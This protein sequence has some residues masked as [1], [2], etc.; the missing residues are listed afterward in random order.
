MEIIKK[1]ATFHEKVD[2]GKTQPIYD[3]KKIEKEVFTYNGRMFNTLEEAEHYKIK[4]DFISNLE[5]E[6]LNNT[7]AGYVENVYLFELTDYIKF[8]LNDSKL[9]DITTIKNFKGYLNRD[10]RISDME[11]GKYLF[12]DIEIE[13]DIDYATNCIIIKI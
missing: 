5:F 4:Y 8:F 12:I 2:T 6:T 13:D 11:I 7:V 1:T 9:S 3:Y 10:K